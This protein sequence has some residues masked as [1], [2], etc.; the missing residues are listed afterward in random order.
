MAMMEISIVPM[1]TSEPGVSKYVA[2]ALKVV[3]ESGLE[4]TLTPMGTLVIGDVERLLQLAAKMHR[5]VL[6][7]VVRVVTYIKIDDRKD[8]D[9]TF[10]EKI[11]SVLEKI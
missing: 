3:K 8:K 4:Y 11:K 9:P 1:G 10:E 6:E 2:K 5:V 7:D